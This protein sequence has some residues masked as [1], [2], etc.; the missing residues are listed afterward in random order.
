[1][2]AR[3][4]GVWSLEGRAL[5]RYAAD[6]CEGFKP[7]HHLTKVAAKR[8][9]K[10]VLQQTHSVLRDASRLASLT[11]QHEGAQRGNSF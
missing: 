2:G 5:G 1:L 7:T 6:V 10:G 3:S 9:S 8:P 11:P 4:C